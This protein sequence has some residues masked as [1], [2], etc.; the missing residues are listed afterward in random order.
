MKSAIVVFCCLVLGACGRP[1]WRTQALTPEQLT[2]DRNQEN[3]RLT[4]RDSTVMTA[5]FPILVGDS[6]TWVARAD[7][8]VAA[9]GDSMVRF[10]VPVTDIHSVE[11]WQGFNKATPFFVVG[12]ALVALVL[13]GTATSG[14]Y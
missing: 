4:L 1:G 9:P 6:L 10:A 14:W 11:R 5:H 13:I 3:L 2:S 12:L 8:K 7:G